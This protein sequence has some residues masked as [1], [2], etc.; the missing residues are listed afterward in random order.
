VAAGSA[1][2]ALGSDTGGSIR[3]PA[4]LTGLV[5]MKPTYGTVSRYGLIAFASSLDQ[6]GPLTRTVEDAVVLLEAIWGHDPLDATSHPGPYPALREDLEAGVDGL[7]IGVVREL[8]GEGYEPDVERAVSEMVERLAG[9]GASVVEVSLPTFDIALSAYYL[10]APAEASANLARFDGI[11]YGLR[12]PGPATE[13]LMAATRAEGFGP[14]V[15]RRILLGTYGLSAGY[16][17]AFYGQAQ[18]VRAAIRQ[19]LARVYA[20]V[21]VLVSPTSP[22]VAFPAGARV[23]DPLAMYLSDICT[24]PSNLSGDPAVSVPI[25][26]D[27]QGLPIGFQVMAPALGEATLIQVAAEV[28]RLAAFD[29]RP[30]LDLVAV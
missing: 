2:G 6:I 30:D 7:R 26:V 17:E 8:A 16:Y 22:T 29:A 15:T 9:N 18:K 23:A 13:Q 11:R 5:G 28:E 12:V 24:I 4:S 3:Q 1:L 10:I 27:G 14:E 19:D 25:A 21:D 20:D